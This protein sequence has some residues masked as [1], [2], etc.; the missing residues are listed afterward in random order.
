[1]G[2]EPHSISD[3]STVE[4]ESL[5]CDGIWSLKSGIL[6]VAD[7]P[8]LNDLEEQCAQL[9]HVSSRVLKSGAPLLA[10]FRPRAHVSAKAQRKAEGE[11]HFRTHA[12]WQLDVKQFYFHPQHTTLTNAIT[13]N[14]IKGERPQHAPI[15]E[16]VETVVEVIDVVVEA[17]DAIIEAVQVAEAVAEVVQ[18]VGEVVEAVRVVEI[19]VTAAAPV[20]VRVVPVVIIRRLVAATRHPS[21]L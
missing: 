17:V 5:Q 7:I 16:V 6:R 4:L 8:L 12:T 1:M 15:G 2:G 20:D 21:H 9:R 3:V 18:I 14:R 10:R 19:A 11:S 13:P